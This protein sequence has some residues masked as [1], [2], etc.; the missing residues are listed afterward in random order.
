MDDPKLF[1]VGAKSRNYRYRL[2]RSQQA[3]S[4]AIGEAYVAVVDDHSA[5]YWNPAGMTH[6]SGNQAG[7]QYTNGLLTLGVSYA[8]AVIGLDK[9]FIGAHLYLFDGGL[10]DVTTLYYP[11]GTGEQFSG[12][13]HKSRLKL[14]TGFN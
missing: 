14:C 9:G 12:S 3:R 13:G 11:E 6:V 8:S 10:M 7:F 2:S 4:I 1:A 5:L